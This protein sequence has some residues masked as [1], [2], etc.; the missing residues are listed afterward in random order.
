MTDGKNI[1]EDD[2]LT[3]GTIYISAPECMKLL[4]M[5]SDQELV[6][7]N[8]LKPLSPHLRE[9]GSGTYM[10]VQECMNWLDSLKDKQQTDTES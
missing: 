7:E 6:D 9:N 1:P 4:D 8:I 3:H 2:S 10:S 5:L